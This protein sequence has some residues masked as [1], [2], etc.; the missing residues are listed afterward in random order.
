VNDPL[1]GP[2]AAQTR[3]HTRRKE[4]KKKTLW[5]SPNPAVREFLD[6]WCQMFQE[7]FDEPYAVSGGKEGKLIQYLLKT[8]PVDRLKELA[9]ILL[10]SKD[11]YIQRAGFTIHPECCQPFGS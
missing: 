3:P 2:K 8:H 1:N 4:L 10:Q 7:R 5:D 9:G 11:S 6:A